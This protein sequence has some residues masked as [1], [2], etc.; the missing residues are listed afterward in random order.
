MECLY[1][2]QLVRQVIEASGRNSMPVEVAGMRT[3]SPLT[4]GHDVLLAVIL[5][6]NK[7]AASGDAHHDHKKSP[8]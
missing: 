7:A 2:I 5:M 1:S 4:E 3:V 6:V 8:V